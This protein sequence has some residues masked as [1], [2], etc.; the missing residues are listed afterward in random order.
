MLCYKL[1]NLPV[2][3]PFTL[4]SVV[5][6]LWDQLAPPSV[7]PFAGPDDALLPLRWMSKHLHHC[8]TTQDSLADDL[9]FCLKMVLLASAIYRGSKYCTTTAIHTISYSQDIQCKPAKI[10][11]IFAGFHCFISVKFIFFLLIT[12]VEP[13]DCQE[14]AKGTVIVRDSPWFSCYQRRSGYQYTQDTWIPWD[15]TT[16]YEYELNAVGFTALKAVNCL[17]QQWTRCLRVLFDHCVSQAIHV[18]APAI[19]TII[20]VCVGFSLY[21]RLFNPAQPLRTRSN[22]IKCKTGYQTSCGKEIMIIG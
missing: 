14:V 3:F 20:A 21:H 13:R 17:Q 11:A 2:Q 19:C 18:H 15:H 8:R 5:S 22:H 1:N 7:V 10:Y 9:Y 6:P 4:P 16:H 12:L